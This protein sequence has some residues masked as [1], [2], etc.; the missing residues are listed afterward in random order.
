MSRTYSPNADRE[1][2]SGRPSFAANETNA[3]KDNDEK[4]L[5]GV[6][7]LTR[8]ISILRLLSHNEISGARLTELSRMTGIPHP[9]VRRILKCLIEE[10]L[11]AQDEASRRYRLGPLN[12]ELGLATYH[13]SGLTEQFRALLQDLSRR[14]GDTV[15]L[16][17]R[18]GF[19]GICLEEIVGSTRLKSNQV[20]IGGRRPL[21]YGSTG[22]ALLAEFPDVEI[23]KIL[24]HNKYSATRYRR[25]SEERIFREVEQ[26]RAN[27]VVV[28]RNSATLGLTAVAMTI[29]AKTGIPKLAVSVVAKNERMTRAHIE[30]TKEAIK[31]TVLKLSELTEWPF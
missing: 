30:H 7:T 12:F 10:R 9:T 23:R 29:H 11:V 13:G 15:Y 22:I 3:G 5:S 17:M 27:G 28:Q 16:Q 24:A 1:P 31:D 20:A 19:E 6:R 4:N 18:S 8:A 2:A 14:T 21:G 25:M 26:A